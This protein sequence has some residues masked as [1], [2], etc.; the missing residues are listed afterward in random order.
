MRTIAISVTLSFLL[1]SCKGQIDKKDY[2]T[3]D[4]LQFIDPM[5]ISISQFNLPNDSINILTMIDYELDAQTIKIGSACLYAITK[6]YPEEWV[7][8]TLTGDC[9]KRKTHYQSLLCCAKQLFR[10]DTAFLKQ[11]FDLYVFYIDKK[12]LGEPFVENVDGGT[13]ISYDPKPN[14]TLI[15]YKYDGKGWLKIES[16][17]NSVIPRFFGERYM[18]KI[19]ETKIMEY[20]KK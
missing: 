17:K 1:I 4:F 15:I 8:G 11:T 2:A 20:I 5:Y 16:T 3:I 18:K 7:K 9:S 14:G 6:K 12:D 10:T 13:S 19:A